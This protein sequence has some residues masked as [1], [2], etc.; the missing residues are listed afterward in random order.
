MSRSISYYRELIVKFLGGR[1]VFCGKTNGLEIDHIIAL[2]K[3]GNN[4]PTNLRLLCKEC[5]RQVTNAQWTRPC[6]RC[7]RGFD[8]GEK[9]IKRLSNGTK[10]YHQ[11]CWLDGKGRPILLNM[12]GY[13][14][15]SGG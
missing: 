3:G 14:Q 1:C 13:I 5:H 10:R 9:A 8:H 12:A 6:H 15:D 4:E 11:Q 7:G 2:G